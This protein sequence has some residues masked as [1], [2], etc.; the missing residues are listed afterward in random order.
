MDMRIRLGTQLG[1]F[2]CRPRKISCLLFCSF[3]LSLIFC[4]FE[5]NWDYLSG[6]S[7]YWRTPRGLVGGSYADISTAWSG[8]ENF[9][10]DAWR[11]PLFNVP[12]LGAP[13]G[14]NIIFTDSI[15]ILAMCGRLIY[16][17]TGIT[18]NPFGWWTAGCF[19]ASGMSLTL[20]VAVRGPRELGPAM[21]A[22]VCGLC[23]PA[24]MARYGHLALMAQ[25]EIII[26][27]VLYFQLQQPRPSKWN[28]AAAILFCAVALWTHVYIFVMVLSVLVA[29]IL[30]AAANRRIS[31]WHGITGL[32]VLALIVCTMVG[33]SGY[34]FTGQP[35][36]DAGFGV[37]STNLMSS[38]VPQLS[39]LFPLIGGKIIDATGGQYEGFCYLGAGTLLMIISTL[40]I[41][42]SLLARSARKHAILVSMLVAFTVFAVSNQIFFGYWRLATIPLPPFLMHMASVFRSSGRFMWPQIYLLTA[43]AIVAVPAFY[44]RAAGGRLLLIAAFL[45]FA[46]TSPLRNA[47]AARVADAGEPPLPEV[48]WTAAIRRHSLI[49]IL[50]PL[51]CLGPEI[52]F[53]RF[54]AVEL[55]LLASHENVAINTVVAARHI[56]SCNT[57]DIAPLAAGEL[58]V[59]M[60]ATPDAGAMSVPAKDCATSDRLA[61][62]SLALNPAELSALSAP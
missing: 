36:E 4:L 62:C 1:A 5:F 49:R 17:A 3:V 27:F 13:G 60:L 31:L 6:T 55:D 41:L 20:L 30:Q 56:E 24:L 29:G 52:G 50:P 57:S 38:F 25:W 48:L 34:L 26:A 54:S 39:G 44:G 7:P 22:T 28:T 58:R 8:Y 2:F 12:K 43:A 11:L 33:V 53:A 32:A 21:T 46:D 18:F 9:V 37:F 51:Y 42:P 47:L 35:V 16:L 61:V 15:P 19:V 45:Q 14:I 10:H 23:M 40:P 59:Y